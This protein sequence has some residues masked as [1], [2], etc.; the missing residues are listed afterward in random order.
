MI[1]QKKMRSGRFIAMA[2]AVVM[3]ISMLS[4][5][6]LAA[7]YEDVEAG[8]Y[9]VDADLS[10]FVNAMGGIEFG[11]PLL[12]G[13]E[14]VVAEDGSAEMTIYFG[15]SQVT[16]YS[17]TCDTFIDATNSAPG[18]Y[19]AGGSLSKSDVTY[20]LSSDT[21]LDANSNAVHYVDSVTFPL[22]QAT[23]SYNL[24]LYVNSNVMG[25]QFCD[26]N[27]SGASNSP[28]VATPYV[29]SLSVDWNTLEAGNANVPG[30]GE[31]QTANVVY[32]AVGGYEVSIPATINVDSYSRVGEYSVEMTY[33]GEPVGSYVTVT[34]AA[35]GSVTNGSDTIAFTNELEEG[36]LDAAGA[37]L[38]GKVTITGRAA[39]TGQYTGTL[40]FTIK[41]VGA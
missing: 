38:G 17:V 15:K 36:Q 16:I 6:A 13:A 39:G 29:A 20:T 41:L 8:T 5:S 35:S 1:M 21:A 2:M 7:G 37:S 24:Y 40:D 11:A 9:T 4:V 19:T 34:S 14:V 27:G 31:T 10:C 30:A 25:V 23:S 3:M 22:D 33:F 12:Q 32:E 18:Y 28:D 26:G